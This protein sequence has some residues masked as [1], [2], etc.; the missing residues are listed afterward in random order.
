[1]KTLYLT[2]LDG[3]FLNSKGEIT[4]ASKELIN[5]LSANGVLFSIASARTFATV[6]PMFS[7]VSLPCPLVLM[8]GVCIFDPVQKKTIIRHTFTSETANRIVEIFERHGKHPMIYFENNS[9]M[10]VEYKML[11]TQS[12]K[13]YVEQRQNFYNKNFFKVENYSIDGNENIVYAATLDKKDELAPIY[14]ELANLND[15]FCHFYP[16]NYC[17]DYFMEVFKKGVSKAS[18][19]VQVK[20]WLNADKIVAFGDN[21]ND[22][23]LFELADESYAVSNACNELKAIATGV[24]GSNDEDAVARFIM[25]RFENNTVDS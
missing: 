1:M 24:I 13:D 5:K 12:Q 21:I 18:G 8:N 20:K 4:S 22:I 14:D 17:D 10:Y 6:V 25:E 7:G 19:A 11:A 16:D 9:N 2:D 3:T 23:P 15:V